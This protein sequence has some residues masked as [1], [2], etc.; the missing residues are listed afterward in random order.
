MVVSPEM[1]D[2]AREIEA[3]DVRLGFLPAHDARSAQMRREVETRR[4]EAA[5]RLAR[6]EA[7][8]GWESA[9]H[10]PSSGE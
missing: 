5:E 2:L 3:C 8:A 7:E 9:A 1:L 4:A 6:L 10:A